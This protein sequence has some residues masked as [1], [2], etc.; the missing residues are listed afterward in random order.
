MNGG[1]VLLIPQPCYSSGGILLVHKFP[2]GNLA[3][4]QSTPFVEFENDFNLLKAQFI[5]HQHLAAD[6]IRPAFS[7]E[8][9]A[10]L[11]VD[12]DLPVDDLTAAL[13]LHG[14]N[15]ELSRIGGWGSKQ[16]FKE[17]HGGSPWG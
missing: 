6:I 10:G 1:N 7:V 8:F 16:F 12:V 4:K 15:M 17:I 11:I 3:V 2:A 14:K 13:A 5:P 9:Q